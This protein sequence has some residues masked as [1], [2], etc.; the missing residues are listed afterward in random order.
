ILSWIPDLRG[1][2]TRYLAMLVE[3]LLNPI[4]RII[5][6]AG[7]FDIAFI[8]LFVL[9]IYV[10]PWIIGMAINSVCIAAY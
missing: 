9:V 6:P 3:P 7:G 5:P 8:V 2:W 10:V 4:R 1:S